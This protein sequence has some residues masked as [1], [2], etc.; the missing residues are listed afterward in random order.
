ME[1][2]DAPPSQNFDTDLNKGTITP[3]NPLITTM[4][5]GMTGTLL[6]RRKNLIETMSV[7]K[8]VGNERTI[9]DR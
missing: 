8:Q 3:I 7:F 1:D 5:L 4:A 6:F 2:P 9:Q